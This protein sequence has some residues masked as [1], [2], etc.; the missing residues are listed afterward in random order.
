MSET[1]LMPIKKL[2]KFYEDEGI[3]KGYMCAKCGFKR[4]TFMPICVKCFSRDIRIQDLPL[5]G[6]VITYTLQ[7]FGPEKFLNDAPYAYVI[8]E[9]DDGT[10]MS[11]WMPDIKEKNQIHIGDRVQLA[12][13]YKP[14]YVFEKI[15]E[16]KEESK[17]SGTVTGPGAEWLN[18]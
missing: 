14:G 10:R 8:V 17:E 4:V 3:L 16:K 18:L 11:G 2:R 5:T 1:E 7:S 12:K 15:K 9:L 13:T 6:K